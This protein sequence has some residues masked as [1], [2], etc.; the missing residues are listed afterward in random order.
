MNHPERILALLSEDARLTPAQLAD[1]VDSTEE[2]VAAAIRAFEKD[3]TILAYKA[4]IDW[5]RPIK[6]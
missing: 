1:M 6:S 5:E 3:K 2:E 4:M